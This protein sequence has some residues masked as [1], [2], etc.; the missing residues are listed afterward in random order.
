MRLLN[1]LSPRGRKVALW[2]LGLV[3]GYT[4]LGFLILPP[5]I[6]AVAVKVLAKQLGREVSIQKVKL[7]PCVL[8][9]TVRG[10]LIKDPDGQPFVSWDEVY[11]NLQIASFFGH[12]WVFKE[13]SMTKPFVRVQVNKDYTFNFSDLLAKGSTNAP[14]KAPSK[15]LALRIDRLRMAGAAASLTDLTPRKPFQRLLGPVDVTLVNFRTD[16]SNK[17]PYT[18]AG[19]TDAGEKFAWSGYFYLDPLRSQGDFSLENLALNKYAPL[20]Q[21]FIRFQVTDGIIGL[22]SS[23]HFELSATNRVAWVTN[24]AF[25]LRSLKITE[26]VGGPELL[27]VPQFKVDGVSVDAEARRAEV[28]SV[29][30]SGARVALRRGRDNSINLVEVAK[31]AEGAA[32]VPG[33]VLFLLQAAT[34]V[35]AMLLN[36]TNAWSGTV[37]DVQFQDCALD[38]EDLANSRPVR[39]A[40][41]HI[42]LSARHL[43]NL[44]GTNLSASLSLRWNTNGT[45]KGDLQASFS[46]VAAD[47]QLGLDQLELRALD[48][49]LES[50]LN[51]F[52]LG[53]KLSMDAHLR[54]RA[55]N[56]ELP[57]VT[58]RGD[59]RLD[60]FATVDGV[61]AED[62]LKWGS[63]RISG[64]E[65][66]LNPETVTIR[67]VAVD[68]AFAR[69]II[70]TNR[71]INLSAAL[72]MT[73]TNGPAPAAPETKPAKQAAKAKTGGQLAAPPANSMALTELPKV[74]VASV[75]FSNAEVRFTDRSVTPNVNLAIQQVGGTL[76]GL[77]TE[78]TGHVEVNLHAKVDKVGPVEITGLLNPLSPNETN[79]I[80]VVVKNVDLTPTSPYVG[81]FAGY[82]LIQGKLEMDLAYHLS[83]RNLK[84][85]NLLVLDHFTFGDK[86]NSPDATKLP[87]RLA[88]AILKDREGKIKLDVP[89]EGSLDDPQFRLHKV[90]VGAIVNLLTKIVTS[91][92]AAL[93]AVFGGR[94][95]EISYQDFV[96]G[97]AE[98]QAAGKEKLDALV[99]GLFE[100]PGLQLEVSGSVEPDADRGGL[101]HAMLE[102][103]LRVAKWMS[104]RKSEQETTGPEQVV[105]TDE[106]R[107]RWLQE[108]YA[109]AVS[110]GQ[111][112]P[113][114]AKTEPDQGGSGKAE[115]PAAAAPEFLAGLHPGEISRGATAL[116]ERPKAKPAQAAAP[117][118]ETP[119]PPRVEPPVA[120]EDAL[121][122]SIA[123]TDNELQA[124][125]VTRAQAVRDYISQSGKVEMERVFLAEPQAE[126]V[127]SQGSRAYLQLR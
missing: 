114:A 75:V 67:E 43:S 49:Y 82:R 76:T 92:F 122:Q 13:V 52:V 53:S 97:S 105:L 66:S 89:I 48:P 23:Y 124:L 103:R 36:S 22:K 123:V 125:A 90:I 116:F 127:K 120:L 1:V 58:F 37:H 39:L 24:T 57:D 115:P 88:V 6:R 35:V 61:L 30:A 85:E 25:S 59:V 15:P 3:L 20:Y 55:T 69:V 79:D 56:N 51:V 27:A 81:K 7:N 28:G 42:N 65:A 87:V 33:G 84:S 11:V 119:K 10:L 26:S 64:I 99:K 80:K 16:P 83:G 29:S 50:K 100:R 18:I 71:T 74:S 93:S 101:R 72:R 126:G 34:N 14:A 9:A 77:S 45:I 63:V 110:K 104:L 40:L 47:L 38:L 60:D 4:I 12:P 107:P 118:G 106:E 78:K 96:A 41:D 2:T 121:V 108:L 112:T 44:P 62:L 17:N 94:G 113:P 5:I 21:D 117:K 32:N 86:V 98:L 102:K 73:G 109:E 95:E 91:P 19:T 68:D 46:P 31:P 70:E 111:I 54:L 8:S